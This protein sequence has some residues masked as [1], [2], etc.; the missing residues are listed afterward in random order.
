[1]RRKLRN[2]TAGRE[3]VKDWRGGGHET[4]EPSWEDPLILCIS[5]PPPLFIVPSSGDAF[6]SFT[7]VCTHHPCLP[8]P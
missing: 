6:S 4:K 5:L 2:T 3:A 7:D 8:G 1:M